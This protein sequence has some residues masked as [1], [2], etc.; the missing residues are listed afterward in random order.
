MSS[1][2]INRKIGIIG[3]ESELSKELIKLLENLKAPNAE[4]SF[5][6]YKA[7][8][9]FSIIGSFKKE[10]VLIKFP[11]INSLVQNDILIIV[12]EFN[13]IKELLKKHKGI[14][15]DLSDTLKK[16]DYL[17]NED[18]KIILKDIK[19]IKIPSASSFIIYKILKPVQDNFGLEYMNSTIMF[20]VSVKEGG[21]KELLSQTIDTLNVKSIKPEIFL[22]PVAFSF[23]ETDSDMED[24]INKELQQLLNNNNIRITGFI[25]PIFHSISFFMFLKSKKPIKSDILKYSYDIM[26]IFNLTDKK[27]IPPQ[28]AS[29]T[30]KILISEIKN[31]NKTEFFINAA[32]D[33]FKTAV[34]NNTIK[35]LKEILE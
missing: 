28:K 34:L 8:E 3:Y 6:D 11:D 26:N 27:V 14:L 17:Y 1:K 31:F 21:V 12:S 19:T 32:A 2:Q 20:P 22:N 24:M 18:N 13:E 35:L 15:I 33:N 16:Y 25:A 30:D 7:K 29:E 9:E 4:Y 23:S 10:S 5:Y